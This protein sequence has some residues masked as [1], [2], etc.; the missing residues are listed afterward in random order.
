MQLDD[1]ISGHREVTVEMATEYCS[2]CG[3][4]VPGRGKRRGRNVRGVEDL[5]GFIP[6]EKLGTKQNI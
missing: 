1:A 3:K 6:K 2:L 4:G 5:C